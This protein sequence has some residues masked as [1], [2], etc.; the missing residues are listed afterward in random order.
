MN[1][2]SIACEFYLQGKWVDLNDYRLQAAGITGR[3][4]PRS[5]PIDRVA[6]TGQL[7]LVLHNVIISLLQVTPIVCR[8]QS[9]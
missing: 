5:N 9:G 2:D 7:T 1:Y 4:E 8:F 6:S 3:W